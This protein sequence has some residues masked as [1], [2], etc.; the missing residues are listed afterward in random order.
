MD[1][2]QLVGEGGAYLQVF[3]Q[4]VLRQRTFLV[5]FLPSLCLA[6]SFYFTTDL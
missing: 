6:F 5:C 2:L 1:L 4:Q 3:F